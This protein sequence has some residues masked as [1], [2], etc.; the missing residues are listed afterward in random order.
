MGLFSSSKMSNAGEMSFLQHLE[1]LRWHLVRCV[2]AIVTLGI[3]AFF[4]IDLLTDYVL[5]APTSTRF[6]TYRA[7]CHLGHMLNMGD[8]FCV[9]KIPM[10]IINTEIAGQFNNAMW[11]AIVSGLVASFPYV[12]WELWRFVKPALQE[13]E[14]KYARGLV[15]YTSFLFLSG[16]AF[17]YFVITPMSVNFLANFQI[18][19]MVENTITLDSI[20]SI[21]TTMTLITGVVFELPIVIYFLSKIGIITPAFMR[22]YRRHAAVVILILAA[23]ITP[24]AD[25]TTMVFVAM[26]LYVLY[27]ISIFV[28]VRVMKEKEV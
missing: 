24:T 26:P 11:I 17:G 19:T 16:V 22:K 25:A 2:L 28:S 13:K 3:A 10:K 27:E 5:L 8:Q 20:I 4:Y 15:F 18:S 14:K 23:I 1:A 7:L 21:V 12:I 6:V 9:S